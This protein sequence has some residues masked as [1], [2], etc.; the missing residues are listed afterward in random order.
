MAPLLERFADTAR[1]GAWRRALAAGAASL[2]W[3]ELDVAVARAA[4]GLIRARTASPAGAPLLW[5]SDDPIARVVWTL[6]LLHVGVVASPRRGAGPLVVEPGA[7]DPSRLARLRAELRPRDAAIVLDGRVRDHAEL[8]R[9]GLR[10][11]H[12]VGG[13]RELILEDD[14]VALTI[15]V[16]G[17]CVAGWGIVIGAPPPDAGRADVLLR[18]GPIGLGERLTR[19]LAGGPRLLAALPALE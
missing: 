14:P 8:G 12:A 1:A 18:L 19:R 7:D 5:W 2:S 13:A 15:A 11:A 4:V 16:A 9:L 17:A 3:S 10:V 6:A